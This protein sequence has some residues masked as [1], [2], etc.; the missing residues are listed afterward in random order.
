MTVRVLQ[1][2]PMLQSGAGGMI[3]DLAIGLRKAGIE[4]EVISSGDLAPLRDW[5]DLVKRLYDAGIAYGRIDFFRRDQEV[6]WDSVGRLAKRLR[7]ADFDLLHAHSGV[8]AMAAHCALDLLGRSTPVVGTFYSWGIGR[9]EWMNASDTCAFARCR[10][11]TVVSTWYRDFLVQRGIP[12]E[13]I[14]IIPPGIDAALFGLA[15]QREGLRRACGFQPGD[16]PVIADLAVIEPRK[17]Q[18]A[19]IEALA[20]L[21]GDLHCRLALIGAIKD[22]RYHAELLE[23]AGRLGIGDRVAFTG[24]V[25]DPYPLLA[26][27]DVFLFPSL[28]EGLGIAILEAMALGVPVVASAVEGAA[29][30]VIDGRTAVEIDPENPGGIAAKVE[31]LLRSPRRAGEMK[32]AAAEMVRESFSIEN[33]IGRTAELYRRVLDEEGE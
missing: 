13:R 28:S 22:E 5:P 24:K 9:P 23:R 26:A 25:D 18:A 19:A 29:D 15:P 7:G 2:A 20:L 14:E 21:P 1:L 32:T 33:L 30:I 4:S 8:P 31:G 27:A 17:N 3:A 12:A 10:A 16:Y 11:M 6:F